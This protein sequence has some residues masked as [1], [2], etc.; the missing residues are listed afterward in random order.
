MNVT[1]RVVR[2]HSGFNDNPWDRLTP[3]TTRFIL[4]SLRG[5]RALR[6]QKKFTAY[7][8]PEAVGLSCRLDRAIESSLE[9]IQATTRCRLNDQNASTTPDKMIRMPDLAIEFEND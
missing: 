5:L 6:V 7:S 8:R 4:S 1:N 2:A 9:M 3:T